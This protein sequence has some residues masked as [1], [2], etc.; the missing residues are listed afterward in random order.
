MVRRCLISQWRRQLPQTPKR[1]I[2]SVKGPRMLIVSMTG[3]VVTA[4]RLKA[5]RDMACCQRFWLPAGGICSKFQ[6]LLMELAKVMR[7]E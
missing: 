3:F 7:N 6:K 4:R 1:A 2:P 5:L